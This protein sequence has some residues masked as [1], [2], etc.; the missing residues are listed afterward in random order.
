MLRLAVYLT[1]RRQRQGRIRRPAIAGHHETVS[2]IGLGRAV[3][4]RRLPRRDGADYRGGRRGLPSVSPYSARKSRLGFFERCGSVSV[5]E[6][7]PD[8]RLGSVIMKM[9][10]E[11]PPDCQKA[12]S[13]Y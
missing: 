1:P 8:F 6:K 7:S 10:G 9:V 2:P 12:I 11:L 5:N 3:P 13:A 4:S